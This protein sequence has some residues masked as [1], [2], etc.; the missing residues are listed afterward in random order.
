MKNKATILAVLALLGVSLALTGCPRHFRP[1]VPRPHRLP[2]PLL[3][4]DSMLQLERQSN[5]VM[6]SKLVSEPAAA[7]SE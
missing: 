6:L 7:R 3:P 4:L 1:H 2:H 5:A